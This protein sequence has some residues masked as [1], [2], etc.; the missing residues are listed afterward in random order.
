[1]S[2]KEF[3]RQGFMTLGKS[4]LDLSDTLSKKAF[5]VTETVKP[6]EPVKPAEPRPDMVAAARNECCLARSCGCFT[7]SDRCDNQA[8]LVI[9]GVGIRVDE[10]FCTGCGT[11]EYVCPV[12]PKAVSLG[13]RK[14]I[15]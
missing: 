5:A 1:M 14:A 15:P 13:I 7:C 3:F 8:I 4:V 12:T 2:R 10:S 11:C 9:P 6:Q